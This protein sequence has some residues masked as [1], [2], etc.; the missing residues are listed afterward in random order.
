MHCFYLRSWPCEKELEQQIVEHVE[1][2]EAVL[3]YMTEPQEQE[4]WE[5]TRGFEGDPEIAKRL[6]RAEADVKAGRLKSSD[7]VRRN[8]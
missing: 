6:E 8:V 5:A 1:Q 2:L 3:D 4:G 7:E